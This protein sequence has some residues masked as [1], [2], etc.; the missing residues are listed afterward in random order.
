MHAIETTDLRKRYGDVVAL[1]GVSL[2][3]EAGT[4]FGLLGTN[5]AGKSTLLK[6]LLRLYDP[7]EGEV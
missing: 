5:G 7:V 3:I 2:S 4:T 1:D 6:L